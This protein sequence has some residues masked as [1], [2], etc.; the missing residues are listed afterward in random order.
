MPTASELSINTSASAMAMATE[1]FG[2]GVT[3]QSASFAGDAVQSGI[4]SG[5]ETTSPGVVPSAT[6][7]ILSTGRVTD[8]TNSSGNTNISASTGVNTLGGINGDAQ[9]NAIAGVA[10][11]D[12]A[13]LNATFVPV[14]N[15]LTMQIVFSSEEYLE[16]VNAGFN[17]AVGI[18]VN[19]V[20]AE[21]TI[22]SGDVSINNINTTTNQNLYVN[23][24]AGSNLYNTE[25]DGFTVTM[26]LKAPVN[27]GVSNTIKIGIADG[28]DAIYDSN[29]LIA[30]HSLQTVTI[31][32]DDELTQYANTAH[33]LNVL[34]NDDNATQT[35]LTITQINGID[36]QPGDS[37]T[38]AT[39]E[40]ITLNAD[41]TLTILSDSD[42]G[43]DVFTYTV[44]DGLGNTDVGFV[45]VK[46]V[47]CFVAGTMIATLNG[48]RPV[49]SLSV[50][51]RVITRD[52]GAQPIRWAGQARRLGMGTDAPVEICAGAFGNHG[53]VLVSQQ[54]RI[55][56]RSGMAQALFGDAEVLVKARDLVNGSSVRL[57]ES[58]TQVTYVHLLF[59][60]HE[61]LLAEDLPSES[62]LPGPET[63][64]SFDADTQG[65]LLRLFPELGGQLPRR[66]FPAARPILRHKE[67]IALM[68]LAA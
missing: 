19:G 56:I 28:G 10:T 32:H 58:E 48:M 6:G 15:I 30:G 53:R 35:A 23:N 55:L 13:I 67:A 17:D 54:H 27:P 60:Q 12:A 8:F 52:H 68:K 34:G 22:G 47:P 16:Y 65:E 3:V 21:L 9:L 20:K 24:P 26:T 25:M 38:L 61:I 49:E 31:A 37:V 51:D 46:T 14:G 1:I 33:V 57:L 42:I 41:G 64:A 62:Y 43:E 5:G 2:S 66:P 29:L 59:D 45:T 44:Q 36:V 18:W 63:L 4:F 7:V 11:Y 40:V 39:G 50:G